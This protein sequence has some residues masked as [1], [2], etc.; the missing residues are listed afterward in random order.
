MKV[1]YKYPLR[2]QDEQVIN[3][4]HAAKPLMVAEQRGTLNIWAEVQPTGET[5][6]G[7]VSGIPADTWYGPGDPQKRYL[8]GQRG[9]S[10]GN[11]CMACLLHLWRLRGHCVGFAL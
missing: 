7:V 4:H 11:L 10:G 9:N 1:I 6:A 3:M 8:P 2:L 5:K